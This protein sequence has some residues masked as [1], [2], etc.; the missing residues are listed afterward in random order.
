MADTSLSNQIF[1]SRN[2]IKNQI[3]EYLQSYLELENVDLVKSSFLSFIIEV[4]ATLTSNTLF[5]QISTYKEFFLT[6]AQLPESILN[7]SSFLGYTANEA[8]PSTASVLITMPFNFSDSATEFVIPTGGVFKSSDIEFKTYYITTVTVTDNST[9]SISVQEGNKTYNFPVNIDITENEFS[10]VLPVKQIK[11]DI[12]EFQI[13]SDLQT[14]QFYDQEVELNGQVSSL[15]VE[16]QEAGSTSWTIYT[17]FNSLF[18]MDDN[19]L[20]YVSSRSDSGILI[21]FGNGLNGVQPPAGGRIKISTSLTKGIDGNVIAG[22]ITSGD[23]IYNTTLSGITQLVSYTVV[24]TSAAVNG[25]DEESLESIRS[26]AIINL[27]ALSRVIS[28]GDFKNIDVII[29]DSTLGSNSLP[30]LKRSDLKVNEISLFTT[31][32]FDG[33]I[34]PTRDAFQEFS[35]TYI[36]RQTEVT[37]DGESFYTIFDMTIDPLNSVAD[38]DYI[39]FELELIPSLTTTFDTDYNMQAT[40]L[41]SKRDGQ[42]AVYELSYTS[43]ESDVGT[44]T[45]NMEIVETGATYPMTNDTTGTFVLEFSNYIVVP[46]GELTYRFHISNS[47]GLVSTYSTQFTFRKSLR[48]FTM[49]DAVAQDSTGHIVYDIPVIKKSYYDGINQRDF[50]LQVLQELMSQVTFKDYR[51]LTDFV[52]LKFG[53]TTGTMT[54]M[55]LNTTNKTIVSIISIPPSPGVVGDIYIVG[56]GTGL[57]ENYDNYFAVCTGVDA[58][59]F[60]AP[61]PDQMV[62]IQSDNKKYI[63]AESGWV[64]PEYN[65]PL[66]IEVD[67]FKDSSYSGSLGDLT[68]AVR[69]AIYNEF[70]SR[71]GININIF[72]S[73]IIDVVQEVV[74]VERCRVVKP[75]SSIF[76]DYD[77]DDFTQTQLLEFSPEYI[78]FTLSN[79]SVR[80]F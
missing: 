2:E 12:Q 34:V 79:I 60:G 42:K 67:V 71:F 7:L 6:K 53:N 11:T 65:I 44:T 43:T 62:L 54:N 69:T 74:G 56:K 5:Y 80:V 46:A 15:L 28:G 45:C 10:F 1:L 8:T 50:E 63:Y 72:R 64:I 32:F 13:D 75:E 49:S 31:L 20:G 23:R 35:S 66:V 33:A 38:Y 18:L 78:Y 41:V 70:S 58:W 57:W 19:D 59:T 55:Q 26:N 14:Y 68:S 30:I 52:S 16:V 73:E 17:S 37:I 24:N 21:S 77:I 36:P 48:D 3:I 51:M 40:K 76:F 22:S 25:A 61:N 29:Q 27:T 9:V 39:L 47:S 4:L